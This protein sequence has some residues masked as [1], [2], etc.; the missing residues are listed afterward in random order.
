MKRF[1]IPLL[2]LLLVAA[3]SV[4][5]ASADLGRGGHRQWGGGDRRE[6]HQG[7]GCPGCQFFGGLLLGGILGGALIAPYAGP[8]AVY[9]PPPP[10]CYTRPGYWAQVPYSRPDGYT[11][12]QNAWVPAQTI[13]Q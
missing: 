7:G 4:P 5:P 12:Y 13:C 3:I 8:P 9:A 1:A 10:T 2:A 6:F 11:I